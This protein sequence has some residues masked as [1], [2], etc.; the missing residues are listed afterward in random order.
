M[1]FIPIQI[2]HDDWNNTD[3]LN[4]YLLNDCSQYFGIRITRT[5]IVC[6]VESTKIFYVPGTVLT[7]LKGLFMMEIPRESY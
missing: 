2:K 6:T 1:S 3:M 7:T 4:T 5:L